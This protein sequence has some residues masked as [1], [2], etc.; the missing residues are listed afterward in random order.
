MEKYME[1]LM[2]DKE[3]VRKA[4][5]PKTFTPNWK[6]L[7]LKSKEEGRQYVLAFLKKQEK[8]IAN[9]GYGYTKIL[10]G[11]LE[12]ILELKGDKIKSKKDFIQA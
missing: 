5:D 8:I 2:K 1:E 7:G 12:T 3:A 10:N 9:R 6:R 4:L 11:R